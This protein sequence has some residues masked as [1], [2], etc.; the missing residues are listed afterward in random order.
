M[1]ASFF[2]ILIMNEGGIPAKYWKTNRNPPSSCVHLA[3][4]RESMN[5]DSGSPR[6]QSDEKS[7]KMNTTTVLLLVVLA[8]LTV[9]MLISSIGRTSIKTTDFYALVRD[10][11]VAT[12]FGTTRVRITKLRD[13]VTPMSVSSPTPPET[14]QKATTTTRCSI[15]PS[16]S[17]W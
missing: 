1:V 8:V 13:V 14:P 3:T 5:K 10:G 9:G 4:E 2:S 15:S 7:S 17:R 11:H 12:D 16:P 6:R